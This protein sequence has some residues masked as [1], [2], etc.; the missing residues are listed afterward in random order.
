MSPVPMVQVLPIS[1]M[2]LDEYYQNTGMTSPRREV[3][4][5]LVQHLCVSRSVGSLDVFRGSFSRTKLVK[6]VSQLRCVHRHK[7][8]IFD[9][10]FQK[11][12]IPLSVPSR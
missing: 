11:T 5:V 12:T 3:E 7:F 8:P 1:Q 4:M 9:K 2:D 10:E 6:E